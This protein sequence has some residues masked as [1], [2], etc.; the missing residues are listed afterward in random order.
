MK[1]ISLETNYLGLQLKNPLIVSSSGLTDSVD[2]IKKVEEAGAAAVV[3]KSLFEEQINNDAGRIED[4]N[5]GY[6]E[7]IDYIRA[8]TKSNSV[9][10]YLKL[11]AEA[12][13]EVNIP[14]IASISCISA[15]EWVDF[16]VKVEQVGADALELNLFFLPVYKENEAKIYENIYYE[17]LD[18]V[19]KVVKIP[20]AV[21]IGHYFTNPVNVVSELY[22]HKAN[23]VVLFNKFYEPDIDIERMQMIAGNV[24]SHASDL[25]LSLRWMALV[26]AELPQ[27]HL[28][29]STGVHDGKAVVKQLL[30]GAQTVQLCSA[31]YLKGIEYIGEMLNFLTEWMPRHNYKTVDEF[32]GMMNYKNIDNPEVYERS[33][34]M[35]YYSN[36]E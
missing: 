26:S 21:K 12:K 18:K 9:D 31:L 23:G 27:I 15:K 36:K 16:A 32:R 11:I 14:V 8:Y 29:A 35:K 24:F 17:M 34:F 10:Q 13:Q 5:S 6:P 33:Q 3:L 30:A 20:V 28:S 2:K 22:F 4:Y 19:K 7:A 1:K 25:H